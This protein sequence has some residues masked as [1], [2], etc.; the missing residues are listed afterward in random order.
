MSKRKATWLGAVCAG[1]IVSAG[2]VAEVSDMEEAD[3]ELVEGSEQA[4]ND[5]QV[6]N[7]SFGLRV[8][9]VRLLKRYGPLESTGPV[10]SSSSA[11]TRWAAGPATCDGIEL[12]ITPEGPSEFSWYLFK[13]FRFFIQATD[14][15]DITPGPK[16]YTPWASAGGGTSAYATDDDGVNA[17]SYRVGVEFRVWPSNATHRVRDFR[18]GLRMYDGGT[19]GA[20]GFTPWLTEGG[21][22]TGLVRDS[23][24]QNPDGAVILLGVR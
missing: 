11:M 5:V 6:E 10:G 20:D 23:D 12:R 4:L 13:D 1:V 3:E 9:T 8:A 7:F 21:G 15:G 18:L 16:R 24:G 22:S 17:S 19:P 14:N 2:C